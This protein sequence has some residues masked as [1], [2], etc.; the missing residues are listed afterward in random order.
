MTPNKSHGRFEPVELT[1]SKG[2]DFEPFYVAEPKVS[3]VTYAIFSV[4]PM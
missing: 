3:R 4:T 1:L 2:L